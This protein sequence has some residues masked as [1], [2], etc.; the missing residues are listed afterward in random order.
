MK[1]NITIHNKWAEI[2]IFSK[3]KKKWFLAKISLQDLPS[4]LCK[5]WWINGCGYAEGSSLGRK[6]TMHSF[7]L[8]SKKGNEIDHINQDKLD[9]RRKN[10]RFVLHHIN[11]LNCKKRTDNKSGYTGVVRIVNP[12]YIGER[13]RARITVNKKEIHLGTYRDKT[14]AIIARKMAQKRYR[15]K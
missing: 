11:L 14:K 13:W 9:N 10:L 2:N 4:V 7:I 8:G 5:R 12:R 3:S 15:S 1:Q 6:I